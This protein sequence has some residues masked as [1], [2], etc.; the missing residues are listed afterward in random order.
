MNAFI[1]D[2]D[3][4]RDMTTR[5]EGTL[6][7]VNDLTKNKSGY[8]SDGSSNNFVEDIAKANGSI[9]F[10]GERVFVLRDEGDDG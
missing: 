4:I 3:I 5:D 10:H 9:V 1:T 7:R 2:E 6:V 8:I